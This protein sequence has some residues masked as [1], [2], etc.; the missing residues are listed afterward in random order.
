MTLKVKIKLWLETDGVY[1][2]GEG[3]FRLLTA[4]QECGTLSKAAAELKMSYRHAWGMIRKSELRMGK[5][6]LVTHKGG[7]DLGGSELT[8]DAKSLL[9][10][11]LQ[12]KE[13]LRGMEK[14]LQSI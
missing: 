5:P 8:A 1:I 14:I 7:K 9:A 2:I 10:K 11:Y 12:V 3:L 13:A 4:I 6:L